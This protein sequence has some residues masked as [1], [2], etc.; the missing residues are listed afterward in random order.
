MTLRIKG[1]RCLEFPLWHSRKEP[2][3][4]SIRMQVQSLASLIGLRIQH[5]HE[6]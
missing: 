6:L 4:G 2:G 1:G 3:L 5:C